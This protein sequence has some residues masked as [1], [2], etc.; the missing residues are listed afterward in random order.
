MDEDHLQDLINAVGSLAE[1]IGLMRD[2]L[3]RNG[4]DDD[5]T[6]YLCGVYMEALIKK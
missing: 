5:D 6:I 4:F 1:I 2:A 3:L